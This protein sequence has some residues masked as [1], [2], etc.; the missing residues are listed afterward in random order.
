[1]QIS[2]CLPQRLAISLKKKSKCE[3]API[4][5]GDRTRALNHRGNSEVAKP[6]DHLG[7]SWE[8]AAQEAELLRL[9]QLSF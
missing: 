5:S 6:G 9:F 2:S 1:M 4:A 3:R 8:I 7:W